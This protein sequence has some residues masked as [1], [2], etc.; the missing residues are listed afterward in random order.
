MSSTHN[1]KSVPIIM[2]CAV[3]TRVSV[4]RDPN[5]RFGSTNAQ[6]MACHEFI[7]SQLSKGWRPVDRLYED[8]GFSGSNMRRPGLQSLLSDIC[9][10]LVDI[11]VVHRLDRLTRHL[12]DL[13]TLMTQFE[14]H[15]VSLVSV[16]QSMNTSDHHGRLTLNLL[17]SFAEFERALIGERTRE[18]RAA[19][20]RQGL[21]QGTASPLGYT[22]RERRL[23]VVPKEADAVRQIFT[24]FLKQTS[25]TAL[26]K[27]L[28]ELG[29]KTKTWLTRT[30][31]R[32]GGRPFDR[33]AIYKLL[34]NRAYLGEV[35]YEDQWR[36]GGHEAIVDQRLWDQ[37]HDLLASRARR[38]RVNS[39]SDS[40]SIFPLKGRVFG[41]D[42]RAMSP[43]LSSEYRGCRYAYYIPQKEIAVGAGASGLPR[44]RAHE[45]H[46][47]IWDY[48]RQHFRDPAPWFDDLPETLTTHPSFDRVL[49]SARLAKLDRVFDLLW[50]V[51][52]KR[53][54]RQLVYRVTIGPDYFVVRVTVDGLIDLIFELLDEKDLDV[55]RAR[56]IEA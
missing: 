15:G 35:F 4:D 46:K 2:R 41:T 9:S 6:F 48:L 5:D 45:L 37:V 52:Q 3:Y 19:T 33:N 30:G 20:L 14:Q 42:G 56:I 34:N 12:G 27:E 49:I 25:V 53:I 16:T 1:D 21:W 47:R 17:T 51:H 39:N 43:W 8:R 44:F 7:A 26:L 36:P 54:F 38:K 31:Q 50:P 40:E 23:I 32:K 13:Q 22:I 55:I 10:G 29:I 24:H 18:K 11:V 28:A